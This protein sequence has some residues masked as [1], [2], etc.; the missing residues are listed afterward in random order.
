MARAS[1]VSVSGILSPSGSPTRG[2]L[3]LF[4]LCRWVSRLREAASLA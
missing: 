1:D 3:L 4:P 2:P